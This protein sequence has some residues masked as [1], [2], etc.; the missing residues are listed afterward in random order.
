MCIGE[1]SIVYSGSIVHNQITQSAV[2]IA[3][4]NTSGERFCD[5]MF[6]ILIWILINA[7]D[8]VLVV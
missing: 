6:G 2:F 7:K 4:I 5:F 3:V 1:Y 8:S